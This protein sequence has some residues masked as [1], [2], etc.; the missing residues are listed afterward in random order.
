MVFWDISKT[1]EKVWY[2][3]LLPTI[4]RNGTSRNLFKLLRDFL[5]CQKQQ[6]ALNGQHSSWDVTARVPQCSILG[7]LLLL[8]TYMIY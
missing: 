6:M 8:F 2:E 5:L 7:S 1:F 3:G 4:N